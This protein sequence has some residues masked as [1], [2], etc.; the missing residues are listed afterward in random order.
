[1]AAAGWPL[2]T[3]GSM[4]M[5]PGSSAGHCWWISVMM[6]GAPWYQPVK[7]GISQMASRVNSSTNRSMS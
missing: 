6:A 3:S 1:M 4:R 2:A 5:S 7:G